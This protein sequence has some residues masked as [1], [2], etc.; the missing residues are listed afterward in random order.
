MLLRKYGLFLLLA[1]GSLPGF[2]QLS[3]TPQ[4]NTALPIAETRDYG[5]PR[6]GYGLEVSYQIAKRWEAVVAF[7]RYRFRLEADHELLDVNGLLALILPERIDVDLVANSWNG[8]L[9]YCIPLD[10]LTAY[11]GIEG[12]TNRITASGYSITVARTYWGIAPVLGVALS[13]APRWSIRADT[14]LHTIFVQED[15]PFV[16]DLIGERITF[17]PLQAGLVYH[18]DF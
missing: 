12:S 15:I 9:R 5:T 7:D 18:L 17:V 1:G 16:G 10:K 2:A 11:V 4:F 13:L 8:G 6:T 3:I 14:R